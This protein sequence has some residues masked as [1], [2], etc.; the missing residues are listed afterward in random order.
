MQSREIAEREEEKMDYR[1]ENHF[2]V[3]Y[4]NE[5]MRGKW[6]ILT[7]EYIGIRGGVLKG[8]SPAFNSFEVRNMN[9]T[10]KAVYDFA[11]QA[12][13]W[14]PFTLDRGKKLE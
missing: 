5:Q 13:H 6:D 9:E 12:D 10:L 14:H 11:M 4:E 3:A 2:I 8:K 7:N 1:K